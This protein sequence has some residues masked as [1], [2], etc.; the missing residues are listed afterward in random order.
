MEI[1]FTEADIMEYA[2]NTDN[3]SAYGLTLLIG[4]D[5]FEDYAVYEEL[6]ERFDTNT[7]VTT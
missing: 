3:E 1:I 2:K 6:L 7:E 5:G 4:P